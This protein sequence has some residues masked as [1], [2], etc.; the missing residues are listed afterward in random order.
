MPLLFEHEK[1]KDLKYFE[2]VQEIGDALFVPSGW[3]HQVVNELDTISINHNWINACNI[4][5]VWEA[6]QKNLVS[7]EDEI[8]EFKDTPE[9]TSQCQLILK[10]LFGM[11]YL[12]FVNFLCY[13]AN[14]RLGQL[15][16]EGRIT[17]NNFRLGINH[18]LFDIN[19]IL[20]IM[21]IIQTLPLN[22]YLSQKIESDFTEIK[23]KISKEL[24]KSYA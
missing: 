18:I 6:L 22:K 10:S 1:F 2:I 16:G 7:V 13:I 8:I 15:Q 12:T 11:D 21:N 20:K 14:K 9:Y 5:A 17:F 3:H 4:E 24:N 19:I 23:N